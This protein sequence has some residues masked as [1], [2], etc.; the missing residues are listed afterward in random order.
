MSKPLKF[1][2]SGGGTGGHIFPAL[3]IADALR[4]KHPQAEFLFVGAKGRMEMKKVPAAGY[5]I[6]GLWISGIQRKL[7]LDNLSFPFKL[8]SSLWR[9][10][11]LIRKFKPSAVIGTGGFASG[12]LLYCASLLGIPCLIQEQNS[13]PGITNRLLGKRVQRICVAYPDMERFFDREKLIL[14]GNP[15]RKDITPALPGRT[16]A[17][18]YFNFKDQNPTLLVLGGSLGSK[19]IN[20]LIMENL[21]ALAES[22]I[23]VIWQC[24]QIYYRRLQEQLPVLNE[25]RVKLTPFLQNMQMAFGAA[26]LVIS[27]AGAGTLSELALVGKAAI[28]IPSPNV[29]EDHQTKNGMALEK[30]GAAQVFAEDRSAAEL[31]ELLHELLT[32]DSKRIN[33]EENIKQMALP[34]AAS[35]IADEVE[36]IVDRS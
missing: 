15:L 26:D 18:Q 11:L 34:G 5:P 24:G 17:L 2:I 13:Y 6:E 12:P 25:N 30:R 16:E 21:P 19:R 4:Q 31:F 9:S 28:L 20:E 29:A 33:L 8:I 32:S 35:Q 27:R 14:T 7:T 23:N 1:M 36:R 22:N 10:F 3:A